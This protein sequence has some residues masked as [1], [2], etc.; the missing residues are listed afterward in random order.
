MAPQPGQTSEVKLPPH[1]HFS[2][3]S[4]PTCGQ[5]IPPDKLEEISGKIA[6]KERERILTITA[7]LEKQY[8][9]ERARA[10]AK[11]KERELEIENKAKRT[12]ESAAAERIAAIEAA[13]R[14]SEAGLQ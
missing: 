9:I 5:A 3:E 11:A 1:L 13:Q 7:Q 6:A 10:D 2:L 12:A 4:C 8:V 14:Q